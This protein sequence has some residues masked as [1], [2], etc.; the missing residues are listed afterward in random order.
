[1]GIHALMDRRAAIAGLERLIAKRRLEAAQLLSM[2]A[3]DAADLCLTDLAAMAY[4]LEAL[5]DD[6]G[7]DEGKLLVFCSYCLRSIGEKSAE[8]GEGGVSHGICGSCS[9]IKHAMQD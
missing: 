8:G 4:G 5:L 1:M 3:A 6:A 2:G 9:I 7:R